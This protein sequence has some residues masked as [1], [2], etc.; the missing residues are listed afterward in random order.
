MVRIKLD[1][2]HWISSN[3]PTCEPDTHC[4][5]RS[6]EWALAHQMPYY[7]IARR[8]FPSRGRG[9]VDIQI[10]L[11]GNIFWKQCVGRKDR[12]SISRIYLF[13]VHYEYGVN[14]RYCIRGLPV[15]LIFQDYDGVKFPYDDTAGL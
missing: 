7:S 12:A 8:V 1:Y 9:N 10:I 6:D 4:A 15:V 3:P 13:S 2:I 11:E 5:F 14:V